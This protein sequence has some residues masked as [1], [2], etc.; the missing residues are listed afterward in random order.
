MADLPFIRARL[1]HI[2]Q[3]LTPF[4]LV[5]LVGAP[6]KDEA[7]R[8]TIELERIADQLALIIRDLQSS[9]QLIQARQE[10]LYNVPRDSRWSEAQSLNQQDRALG[11]LIKEAEGL[12]QSVRDI[13]DRNGLLSPIQKGMRLKDLVENFE[14]NQAQM[15]ATSA[16]LSQP[17]FPTI[18]RQTETGVEVGFSSL[19]PVLI[20]AYLGI[21]QL[22]HKNQPK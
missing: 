5:Y 21:K 17:R 18:H 7:S 10:A 8:R 15:H 20:F 11:D 19:V 6:E 22:T 13:L 12:A 1:Q 2:R 16:F 14:K 9:Q 3:G 4:L